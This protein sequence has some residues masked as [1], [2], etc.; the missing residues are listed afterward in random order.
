MNIQL[1]K[2][3]TTQQEEAKTKNVIKCNDIDEFTTLTEQ[4]YNDDPQNVMMMM[5]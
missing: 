5:M 3:S 2:M 4:L 1:K